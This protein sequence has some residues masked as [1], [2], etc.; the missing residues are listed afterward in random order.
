MDSRRRW[1]PTTD[2][3]CSK[4]A[5]RPPRPTSP[6]WQLYSLYN[7]S[8]ENGAIKPPE[9]ELLIIKGYLEV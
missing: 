1:G 3:A 7:R 8:F 2:V 5:Q 9:E 6:G 4:E